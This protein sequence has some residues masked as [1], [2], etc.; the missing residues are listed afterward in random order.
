MINIIND[1][2]RL[3]LEV[4]EENYY[5]VAKNIKEIRFCELEKN[6]YGACIFEENDISI[7]ISIKQKRN[8]PMTIEN[9]TEILAHELA[10]AVCGINNL[11]HNEEW[12]ECFKNIHMLYEKKAKELME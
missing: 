4:F 8:K 5:N 3:T 1:P 9:S 12:L 6:V 11:S 2:I 10:H 7:Y